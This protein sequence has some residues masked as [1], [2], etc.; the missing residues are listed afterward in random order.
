MTSGVFCSIIIPSKEKETL[1]NAYL[2]DS[3]SCSCCYHLRRRLPLW[4]CKTCRR[5]LQKDGQETHLTPLR[6]R[7]KN[8]TPVH[9]CSQ[10]I[11]HF[12]GQSAIIVSTGEGNTTNQKGKENEEDR[13]RDRRTRK[14]WPLSGQRNPWA[15]RQASHQRRPAAVGQMPNGKQGGLK[16]SPSFLFI[17]SECNLLA[18]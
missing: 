17:L 5:R 14:D 2:L 6:K 4:Y 18:R 10:F 15:V 9:I 12:P 13:H 7:Q 11:H 8:I 16:T 3:V 1:N